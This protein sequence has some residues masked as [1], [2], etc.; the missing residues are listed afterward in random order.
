[1]L[2]QLLTYI[3]FFMSHS[4]FCLTKKGEDGFNPKTDDSWMN[5]EDAFLYGKD[6]YLANEWAKC[7]YYLEKAIED[8]RFYT[9]HVTK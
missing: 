9:D 1:M 2:Y 5:F 4:S 8:Y 6:A 3:V 7:V